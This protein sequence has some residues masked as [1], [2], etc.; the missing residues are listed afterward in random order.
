MRIVT[1]ALPRVT[2]SNDARRCCL[3]PWVKI[4]N[5]ARRYLLFLGLRVNNDAS[6]PALPWVKS[7]TTMCVVTAV[8]H[9]GYYYPVPW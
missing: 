7:Y 4:S 8:M 2:V 6:L 3:P 1:A 9:G 5:D